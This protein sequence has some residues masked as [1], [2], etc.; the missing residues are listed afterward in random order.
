MGLKIGPE[1][2]GAL[3]LG[4]KHGTSQQKLAEE[5]ALVKSVTA[6]PGATHFLLQ[7]L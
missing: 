2:G 1:S 4:G 3:C 5:R 6:L 7:V